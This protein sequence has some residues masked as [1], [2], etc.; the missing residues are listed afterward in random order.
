MLAGGEIR[1]NPE[2]TGFGIFAIAASAAATGGRRRA[3]VPRVYAAVRCAEE[4]AA[5]F[6]EK[7]HKNRR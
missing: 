7:V 3:A 6:P 4:C 5:G 1:R 2:A